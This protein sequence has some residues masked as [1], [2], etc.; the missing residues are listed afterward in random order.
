MISQ[1]NKWN[2]VISNHVHIV[3]VQ[4]YEREENWKVA[5]IKLTTTITIQKHV[6]KEL[7]FMVHKLTIRSA[8]KFNDLFSNI[9]SFANE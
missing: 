6:V 5:S 7:R 8:L 9:L 1:E 4:W 2:S 3:S